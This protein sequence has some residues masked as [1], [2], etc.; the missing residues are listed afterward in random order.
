MSLVGSSLVAKHFGPAQKDWVA[1]VERRV[2]AT[3]SMLSN[4][5]SIKMLGLMDHAGETIE[6]LRAIEIDVSARFR[7]LRVWAIIIGNAPSVLAPFVTLAVYALITLATGERSLP[8]EKAFTSLALVT[9]VTE[10]LLMLCQ[11]LPALTQALSCFSR[12]E[13]FLMIPIFRGLGS[14]EFLPSDS[15]QGMLLD[16]LAGH[17]ASNDR[18]LVTFR[19]ADI[20]WSPQNRIVLHGLNLTIHA[21]LTAIVGSVGSGKTSLLA[22]MIGE[23][24][25][26]SGSVL[27]TNKMS[28]VAFCS[29]TPW[30]VND[31]IKRNIVGDSEFD[32]VWFDF[33]VSCCAL[34]KDLDCLP[35]GCLTVV[36][37]N[38]SSLSGGQRQ[39]VALARAVYSKIPV[40]ILDD[41]TSGLDSTAA[42][43]ITTQLFGTDGHFRKAGVSVV[44]ATHNPLLLPYMDAIVVLDDGKLV[45]SGSHEEIR[46]Q[47]PEIFST[48]GE[49]HLDPPEPLDIDVDGEDTSPLGVGAA[50]RAAQVGKREMGGSRRQKGSWHVY[51]Y[52]ANKAGKLSVFLWG[53]STLGGAVSSAYSSEFHSVPRCC[54]QCL[55]IIQQYGWTGGRRRM[56]RRTG[57]VSLACILESILF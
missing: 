29:Q 46:E 22:S 45:A 47:R 5:K 42:R 50:Q 49:H 4:I 6:K 8:V 21:G 1:C 35:A 55:T 10:P 56:H 52:Y 14:A 9:L 24:K 2:S 25:V 53:F 18:C 54:V 12:I 34:Q 44:L 30:L 33:A 37:T 48:K 16:A 41:C 36:G 39:R 20:C 23:T 31:T 26:V 43:T 19:N 57:I 15:Q 3:A 28:R 27:L 11:A 7:A 13:K 38:G 17:T 51:L 32:Q 40:I